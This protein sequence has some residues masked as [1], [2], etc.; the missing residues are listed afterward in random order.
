MMSS[1]QVLTVYEG[2]HIRLIGA[3]RP[4]IM[5]YLPGATADEF[6]LGTEQQD[7]PV[8]MPFSDPAGA[9]MVVEVPHWADSQAIPEEADAH[10]DATKGTN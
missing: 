6:T 3:W 7:G 10:S 5:I 4:H 1:R 8:S 2:D 9:E